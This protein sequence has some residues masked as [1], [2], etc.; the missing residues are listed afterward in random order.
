MDDAAVVG[1]HQPTAAQQRAEGLRA[2]GGRYQLGGG[3]NLGGNSLG[4]RR[5]VRLQTAEDQRRQAMPF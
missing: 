5:L 4:Q 2:R 3:T 1:H